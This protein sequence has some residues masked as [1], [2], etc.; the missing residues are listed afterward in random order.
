M[1]K[2]IL[3]FLM[4]LT[5]V[6]GNCSMAAEIEISQEVEEVK[7]AQTL[8]M[9]SPGWPTAHYYDVNNPNGW[10]VDRR[11][12]DISQL[13]REYIAMVDTSEEYAV[14][15]SHDIESRTSGKIT[16]ETTFKFLDNVPGFS[17]SILGEGDRNAVKLITENGD[18][19]YVQGKNAVKV[20]DIEEAE[21]MPI[22]IIADLDN[23]TAELII[24]GE[25][26]DVFPFS[27]DIGEI[28]RVRLK[29]PEERECCSSLS[30]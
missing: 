15:M 12:G 1:K 14:T 18:L 29:T 4:A 24:C 9:S 20:A 6:L 5:V 23:R 8:L 25:Y 17:F 21:W 16:L 30:I 7:E 13:Y 10:D 26:I 22:K 11:G 2:K 27:E 28:N 19:K 3:A